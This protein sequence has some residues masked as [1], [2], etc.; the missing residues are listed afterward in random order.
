M[1]MER[2]LQP[3]RK[4]HVRNL[5]QPK[6]FHLLPEPSGNLDVW[7]LGKGIM[8]GLLG[9]NQAICSDYRNSCLSKNGM[10]EDDAA[11]GYDSV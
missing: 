5:R 6:K 4:A 3:K 8:M 2:L 7:N 1:L 10:G 9:R 11:M